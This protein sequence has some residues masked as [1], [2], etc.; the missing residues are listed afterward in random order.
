M[1][2]VALPQISSTRDEINLQQEAFRSNELIL[3][4]EEV[5]AK[6]FAIRYYVIGAEMEAQVKWVQSAQTEC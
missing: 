1:R 3:D 4:V 2:R 6:C 5:P